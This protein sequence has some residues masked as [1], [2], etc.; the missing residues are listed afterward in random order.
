MNIAVLAF[1]FLAVSQTA[2]ADQ[3]T[4]IDRMERL[5]ASLPARDQ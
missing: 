3:T 5:L 1:S 4:E 2:P